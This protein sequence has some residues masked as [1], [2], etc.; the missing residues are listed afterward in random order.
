VG[1]FIFTSPQGVPLPKLFFIG[2]I[3]DL[4]GM[5]EPEVV[6]PSRVLF[7]AEWRWLA[8]RNM[9]LD[10]WL[11]RI[12]GLQPVFFADTGFLSHRATEV[13][14]WD[15]WFSDVGLALR[16]HFDAFGVRPMLFRLDLAQRIDPCFT[17][18]CKADV[19][20]YLGLGQS[21]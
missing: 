9:D 12:R 21:F 11:I 3:S 4:R 18:P 15:D 19:R 1:S 14:V 16:T 8:I 17:G 2:G 10:L 5:S 13:P 20:L 7:S 6:G